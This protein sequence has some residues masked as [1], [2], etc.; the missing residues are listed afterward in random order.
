MRVIT[1]LVIV[2]ALAAAGATAWYWNEQRAGEAADAGRQ[3]RGGER[4]VGVVVGKPR[5]DTVAV[6]IEAVGTALAN[7]AVSITPKVSGII[8][9]ISFKE[10]GRVKK[11]D[12]LVQL[13]AT[14][15]NA[16]L[17]EQR[18]VLEQA[19]R[20]YDRALR[21]FN[22]RTVS[23]ARIDELQA[24]LE[25]AKARVRANEARMQDY[26]IRAPFSGRLGLRRV[27]VGA[28]V[29]PGTEITTLDD[30]SRIKVDF[31]VPESV[32][33]LA[34]P[35]LE[36]H[37]ESV[38]YSEIFKGIVKTLDSRID[39]VT[40]SIELRTEFANP[41]GRL[42][43]GMFLTAK[44]S[45]DSRDNAVLVPEEALISRGAIHFVFIVRDG[46]ASRTRVK[47]GER[48]IGEVEILEGVSAE[49]TLVVRGLQKIRDGSKVEPIK[50]G[51]PQPSKGTS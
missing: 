40:R 21:L 46:K 16:N 28:L 24:S 8:G 23:R 1:Q 2:I 32:L 49:D 48:L 6:T 38:T 4:P 35:G 5:V 42:K 25:A 3:F 47:I 39:P 10:G 50:P 15:L 30:T 20:L 9:R 51:Q 26:V 12:V 43:P 27:S 44:L 14:E 34:R 19:Q 36:I 31:R 45:I 11:G 17:E 37:A 33:A 29:S 41:D 7:E 18:I 22:N 13:D